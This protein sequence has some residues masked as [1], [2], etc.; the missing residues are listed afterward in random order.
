MPLPSFLAF[1]ER[2]SK[3]KKDPIVQPAPAAIEQSEL[4]SIRRTRGAQASFGDTFRNMVKAT[5][6]ASLKGVAPK[7]VQRSVSARTG[8][9]GSFVQQALAKTNFTGTEFASTM[10]DWQK[11]RAN[12]GKGG[13]VMGA[14]RDKRLWFGSDNG[15]NVDA[16]APIRQALSVA[17]SILP[18]AG[19]MSPFGIL[20][21]SAE[22]AGDVMGAPYLKDIPVIQGM[23]NGLDRATVELNPMQ[24]IRSLYGTGRIEAPNYDE[25]NK[26]AIDYQKAGVETPPGLGL[27]TGSL[28]DKPSVDKFLDSLDVKKDDSLPTK[29]AKFLGTP[30]RAGMGFV[31]GMSPSNTVGF[32]HDVAGDAKSY[33]TWGASPAAETL[34]KSVMQKAATEGLESAAVKAGREV[35]EGTAKGVLSAT[36]DDLGEKALSQMSTAKGGGFNLL[37]DFSKAMADPAYLRDEAT[38]F[39]DL[40]EKLLTKAAEI[41][42]GITSGLHQMSS[43]LGRDLSSRVAVRVQQSAKAWGAQRLGQTTGLGLEVPLIGKR[44]AGMKGSAENVLESSVAGAAT[45]SLVATK[46]AARRTMAGVLSS[47][48]GTIPRALSSTAERFSENPA[49]TA[50]IYAEDIARRYGNVAANK[51]TLSAAEA[52]QQATGIDSLDREAIMRQAGNISGEADQMTAQMLSDAV[53]SARG[54]LTAAEASAAKKIPMRDQLTAKFAPLTDEVAPAPVRAGVPKEAPRTPVQL[55]PSGKPKRYTTWQSSVDDELRRTNVHVAGENDVTIGTSNPNSARGL[56]E[57][58]MNYSSRVDELGV[59]NP[60]AVVEMLSGRVNSALDANDLKSAKQHA[61]RLE[62]YSDWYSRPIASEDGWGKPV[63]GA[64]L[65]VEMPDVA[66]HIARAQGNIAPSRAVLPEQAAQTVSDVAEAERSAAEQG[67]AVATD[68][69]RAFRDSIRTDP[70]LVADDL[71]E[72]AYRSAIHDHYEPAIRK[73]LASESPELSPEQVAARIETEVDELHSNLV[74]PERVERATAALLGYDVMPEAAKQAALVRMAK[75]TWADADGAIAD[76]MGGIRGQYAK[77]RESGV[78]RGLREAGNEHDELLKGVYQHFAL[79]DN[80]STMRGALALHL[81]DSTLDA[82]DGI[83]VVGKTVGDNLRKMRGQ[84]SVIRGVAD[85]APEKVES[86]STRLLSELSRTSDTWADYNNAVKGKAEGDA[87]TAMAK[88][89]SEAAHSYGAADFANGAVK[90]FG[91][92]VHGRVQV[93]EWMRVYSMESGKLA[94]IPAGTGEVFVPKGADN[95][96]MLPDTIGQFVT[97]REKGMPRNVQGIYNNLNAVTTFFKTWAAPMNLGFHE[98]NYIGGKWQLYL[99]DGASALSPTADLEAW[100]F[101]IGGAVPSLREKLGWADGVIQDGNGQARS[102]A[103]VWNSMESHGLADAGFIRGDLGGRISRDL[104][105]KELAAEGTM[106][107]KL[108]FGMES[109]RLNPLSPEFVVYDKARSL[110][111]MV[112]IQQRAQGFI[113][114][115][116]V[117]GDDVASALNTKRYLFDYGDNTKTVATWGK[118]V[119][120]FISWTKNNV[121]LQFVEAFKRP[122]RFAAYSH[123]ADWFENTSEKP[124]GEYLGLKPDYIDR[125]QGLRT[126]LRDENGDPIYILSPFGMN[127][128]NKVPYPSIDSR[129]TPAENIQRTADRTIETIKNEWAPMVNPWLRVP[130]ETVTGTTAS[131]LPIKN[132]LTY[133]LQS[134]APL[135]ARVVRLANP[136]MGERLGFGSAAMAPYSGTSMMTGLRSYP[137]DYE[138]EASTSLYDAKDA[139]AAELKRRREAAGLDAYYGIPTTP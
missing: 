103:D 99:K 30:V 43:E 131:G 15:I 80:R 71:R 12:E 19:K 48:F 11:Q 107:A 106:G 21:A 78:N 89:A 81:G 92:P 133:P 42:A 45:P 137:V 93:P 77:I 31:A 84:E 114:D 73:R 49:Q 83:P 41:E 129:F 90:K 110:G 24:K 65:P 35:T 108:K 87:F 59:N 98:R 46:V 76:A 14:L 139:W 54:R 117:H 44:I 64:P 111:G 86:G 55:T 7:D 4:D 34:G 40:S 70:T 68:T 3:K 9:G 33:V 58:D 56:Y 50:A 112:E 126:S 100:R 128:L 51:A 135:A 36:W 32:V 17:D 130:V 116:R 94:E 28:R 109:G 118:I 5:Q 37:D 134:A 63:A 18:I 16:S 91:V 26:K 104:T 1:M 85:G 132:K 47:K 88:Y 120:P 13:D 23:K 67:L 61:A 66:G 29:T 27:S 25:L 125:Q 96:F 127:D 95:V 20:A 10:L 79:S 39:P 105:A 136:T 97:T 113:H 52:I 115:L 124:A 102:Y 57:R 2:L 123:A 74:T 6:A 119:F 138:K 53:T 121:P 69:E 62:E 75:E 72:N 101:T 122:G 8:K 60:D 38:R 22:S 82:I